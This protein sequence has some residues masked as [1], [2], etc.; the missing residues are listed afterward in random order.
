MK[1]SKCSTVSKTEKA[2]E[3]SYASLLDASA[4]PEGIYKQ[5]SLSWTSRWIVL[6]SSQ[7]ERVILY[8]NSDLTGSVGPMTG[9]S[10]VKTDET[11]CLEIIK[12]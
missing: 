10:F 4:S 12:P 9:C 5:D 3:Y 6:G 7:R 1:V 11:L 8:F 2:G